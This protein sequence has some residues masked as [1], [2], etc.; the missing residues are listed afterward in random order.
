MPNKLDLLSPKIDTRFGTVNWNPAP[1]LNLF[2]AFDTSEETLDKIATFSDLG[3]K[4]SADT[5][6]SPKTSIAGFRSPSLR[7][8]SLGR[9]SVTETIFKRVD[10]T[11]A[12]VDEGTVNQTLNGPSTI[13]DVDTVT[14]SNLPIS[15]HDT[16]MDELNALTLA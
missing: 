16:L 10:R 13:I 4:S 9:R 14:I 2:S 3:R 5:N 8:S 1:R 11:F 15:E 12:S 6:V 7:S